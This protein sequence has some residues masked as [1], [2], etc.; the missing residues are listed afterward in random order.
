MYIACHTQV[1][2]PTISQLED[3][4][5]TI[6]QWMAGNRLRLNEGKTDLLVLG[7][8]PQLCN[9]P[10]VSLQVGTDVIEQSSSCRNLGVIFDSSM[11]M[12]LNIKKTCRAAN[13]QIRDIGRIRKYLS[14][15]CTEQLVHSFITTRLDYC[16]CLLYGAAKHH[17]NHLQLIQNT[18]ARIVTRT[19]RECHIRPVLKSLH[20]LPIDFRIIFKIVLITFKAINGL[21]PSYISDLIKPY[22]PGRSLRSEHL[23]LLAEPRSTLKTFGDRAFCKVAPT[24][25]NKLLVHLRH[26]QSL[27]QF[28]TGLKTHLFQMAYP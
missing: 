7:T 1:I 18:A 6:G 20:W 27:Q 3:C 9:I 25:W 24:L 17:L 10:P 19:K 8:N 26:P 22:S 11:N 21:A 12:E 23:Y 4:I 5:A 14:Q 2:D 15:Q 28:K 16:N 13:M